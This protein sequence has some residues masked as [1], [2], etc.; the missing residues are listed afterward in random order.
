MMATVFKTEDTAS[1]RDCYWGISYATDSSPETL[2]VLIELG[3]SP[4]RVL[5]RRVL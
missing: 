1:L 5:Y 2:D 3:A 4:C